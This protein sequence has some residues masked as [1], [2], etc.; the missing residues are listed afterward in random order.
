MEKC[1]LSAKQAFELAQTS[2]KEWLK[3]QIFK[4]IRQAAERGETHL[5]WDFEP[6]RYFFDEIND[7]LHN[8]GYGVGVTEEGISMILDIYWD[9]ETKIP[10]WAGMKARDDGTVPLAELLKHRVETAGIHYAAKTAFNLISQAAE[11]GK[12]KVKMDVSDISKERV[13]YLCKII[14]RQNLIVSYDE[15]ENFIEISF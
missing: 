4:N 3:N 11:E 2:G 10:E 14:E 9:T 6:C 5:I 8:L 15:I 12:N 7:E 1:K 13:E